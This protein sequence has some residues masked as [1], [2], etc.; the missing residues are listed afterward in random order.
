MVGWNRH[1]L[2]RIGAILTDQSNRAPEIQ[3][4]QTSVETIRVGHFWAAGSI[5]RPNTSN[6]TWHPTAMPRCPGN[7]CYW[8]NS[9]KHILALRIS[10]FDPYATSGKPLLDR[11]GGNSEHARWNGEAER[12]CGH[13]AV[14][15]IASRNPRRLLSSKLLQS[16]SGECRLNSA[17]LRA[18]RIA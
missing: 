2:A 6:V 7:V 10:E 1:S 11:L 15:P 4:L 8:M 14:R 18:R 5:D 16:S 13:G 17:V 9:G 3:Q 12:F